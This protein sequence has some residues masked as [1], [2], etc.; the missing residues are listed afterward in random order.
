MPD[1]AREYITDALLK[2]NAVTLNDDSDDADPALY[3]A[4]LR[5]W[6]RMISASNTNRDSI[7]TI[8]LDPY[9][10]V[11]NKKTYTIGVDP[12]GLVTADL[13]GP[14]PQR[15]ESA[16]VFLSQNPI[17]RRPM[18]ILTDSDWAGIVYQDVAAY[19]EALYNDGGNP[20]STLY[21]YP[22]PAGA[23]GFELYTWQANA[24]LADLFAPVIFPPGY[25]N[26]WIYQMA[27]NFCPIVQRQP[28]ALIVQM[29]KIYVDQMQSMNV[30][31]IQAH[32]DPSIGLTGGNGNA[33]SG[34][35]LFNWMTRNL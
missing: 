23:Y 26:Y 19:P 6:N 17:V 16:N 35:G 33:S 7:F 11:A 1:T 5:E 32:C 18:R 4:C 34:R 20:L 21:F 24:Q 28:S 27:L 8:R 25:E 12:M 29:A 13:S 15:I 3:A 30:A 31:Q 9:A 2:I 14:R 10:F 22:I